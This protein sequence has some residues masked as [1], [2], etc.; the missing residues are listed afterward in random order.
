MKTLSCNAHTVT[1]AEIHQVET[2]SA[3]CFDA[4]V[5]HLWAQT[6]SCTGAQVLLSLTDAWKN[7]FGNF[8]C[9]LLDT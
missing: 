3:K 6:C 9:C 1:P 5:P 8:G 7:S 2:V 4:L